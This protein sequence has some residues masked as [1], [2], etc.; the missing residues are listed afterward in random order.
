MF[1]INYERGAPARAFGFALT[2]YPTVL[3]MLVIVL[4]LFFLDL[5]GEIRGYAM[6][7]A[8]GVSAVVI[9]SRY[10]EA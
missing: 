4:S 2:F 8:E 1:Y 5:A 3:M 9:M 10:I 7:K 6:V